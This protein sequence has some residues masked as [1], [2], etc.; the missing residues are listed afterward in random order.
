MNTFNDTARL[1][2]AEY[3]LCICSDVS[4]F[5]IKFRISRGLWYKRPGALKL[6]DVDQY[7]S[8]TLETL[9]LCLLGI[10]YIYGKYFFG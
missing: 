2:S 3:A 9:L 10:C 5:N 1:A 6:V 7:M 8:F 4:L